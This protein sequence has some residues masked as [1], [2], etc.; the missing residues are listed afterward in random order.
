MSIKE[1][2]LNLI[3]TIDELD[4]EEELDSALEEELEEETKPAPDS[5]EVP[6]ED[7]SSIISAQQQIA[8][9]RS[10]LGDL[11][12]DFERNKLALLRDIIE[13]ED[14]IRDAVE[15]I[16]ANSGLPEEVNYTFTIPSSE[17]EPGIFIKS[18][19]SD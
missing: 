18:E 12:H 9:R 15:M 6:Y 3:K 8:A 5:L 2:L 13:T 10:Q 11:V 17:K 1:K 19:N 4:M 16:R 14:S 7:C